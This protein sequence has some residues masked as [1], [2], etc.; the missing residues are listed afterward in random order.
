MTRFPLIVRKPFFLACCL[1]LFWA[2]GMSAAVAQTA[3]Q[4]QLFQSLS[5]EQQNAIL[6]QLTT[7]GTL[8]ADAPP[9]GREA[10]ALRPEE[11]ALAPSGGR[12]GEEIGG[13]GSGVL[14][15]GDVVIVELALPGTMQRATVQSRD[16]TDPNAEVAPRRL[17][18]RSE[19]DSASLQRANRLIEQVGKRNPYE[20][21]ADGYLNLPGIPPILLSGLNESQ[22][23]QRLS[24]EPALLQ[25]DVSFS[26]LPV[27][28]TGVPG[29]KPF[30]YEL[31]EELPQ[32]L[33]LVGG[34]SVPNDYVIGPGDVLNVQLFGNQN[35]NLRL[36]VNRDGT[37]N[38]P[39]LGPISVAGLSFLDAKGE[40]EQRV[41]NQMIG[42]QGNVAM[43]EVRS[44][45][46]L[47]LGETRQPGYHTVSGLA[48]ITTALFVSGGVTPI[49]SLRN[50]EL[51]REGRLVARLDLYDLLARG[52]SS[53]DMRVQAGDVIFIPPV[54]PVVAVDGEV[55]RPAIY[56]LRED[57][58]IQDIVRLAGGLTPEAD[59]S[60][61]SI[62][63]IDDQLR[64]V[65]INVDYRQTE[66]RG[67][68]LSNGDVLHVGRLRPQL[69]VGV[70]I[71]GF[72]HRPGVV[73]WRPGLRLTDV[74]ISIDE[75]KPSA[76]ANY[77]LIRR[78]IGEDRR[79]EVLSADLMAAFAQPGGDADPVLQPRD[80]IL[81]FELAP[82]RERIIQPIL[83]EI[84]LQAG[85]ASPTGVV[86]VEGQ[87]KA[88]GDYP[89]EPGMRVSDLIRAGGGLRP[90]AFGLEAELVRYEVSS[91][92]TRQTELIQVNLAEVLSGVQSRDVPLRPFDYLII[93]QAPDWDEQAE[94]TVQGEVRFPGT[95][96]IRKGETLREVIDRAGG[97]TDLAFPE[98]SVF[99]REDLKRL[100]Q[101][102]LDRLAERMQSDLVALSLQVSNTGQSSAVEA[103]LAGRSLLADLHR[104]RATG[105]FVIDLPAIV[106]QPAR[107]A[108][109]VTLRDGDVLVVPK[110]RQEVTVIGE[111]QNASSHF[112][113][114]QLEMSDYIARSGGLTR[115]ADKRRV[116][117]V[118]ANGSVAARSGS[119]LS[120]R[121]K[122]AIRPGDTIVVPVNTERMP[123]L[124][125]WQAV[126]Q[127]LYNVAIATAAVNAL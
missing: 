76:D 65:V 54:G 78:E 27:A 96:P 50:V 102:Q 36:L 72:V 79:L 106:S 62:T 121:S 99:M 24:V 10:Q 53:G 103:L 31:F 46:V 11:G 61:I 91:S 120:R 114:S 104:A 12:S 88:P 42:V 30:G 56:E 1:A 21:D 125:F 5:P 100:E 37:V 9:N 15:P 22:A 97:L 66:A 35:R 40:I 101:E 29:L 25:L 86:R 77:V 7:N 89:L 122:V 18:S 119:W 48:T 13:G 74:V 8:P 98:G 73:A 33:S 95:Y 105:R 70:V 60:R 67:Q 59:P 124:P 43:G 82:G 75:L 14:Q 87:V 110:R 58:S 93:R 55:R 118:R 19:L 94:V 126:T 17:R 39:E 44:I 34:A 69:D 16:R 41:S 117:V 38:F 26:H 85:V 51:R 71:E 80:R 111:V 113:E 28:K 45:P 68:G 112:Y 3:E 32:G 57:T 20:L 64:R 84:R 63:R 116:Y 123:R 6:N 81:V 2:L 49:G 127:I 4:L 90:S 83:D 109:D 115:K 52:D 47:V 23:V 108:R 92:G 107:S